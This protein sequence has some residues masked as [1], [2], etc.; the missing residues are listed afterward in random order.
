MHQYQ[1]VAG[2]LLRGVHVSCSVTSAR[3]AAKHGFAQRGVKIMMP[4]THACVRLRHWLCHAFHG[5]A[6]PPL[7]SLSPCDHASA[8]FAD[9][10]LCL[11]GLRLRCR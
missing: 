1:S 11:P 10:E 5:D 4:D 7:A 2:M 3:E 9:L 6:R 8:I